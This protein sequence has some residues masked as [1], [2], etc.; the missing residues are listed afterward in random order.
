MFDRRQ[1]LKG[2]AG[3]AAALALPR[4]HSQAQAQDLLDRPIRLVVPFAAGGG[5]DALA[6]PLAVELGKAVNRTVVVENK[7]SATGQIGAGEVAKAAP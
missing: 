6:R 3:L 2:A 1:A 5:V 7:P 4:A